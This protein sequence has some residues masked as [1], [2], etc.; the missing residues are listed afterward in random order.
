MDT[1]IKL[2]GH[3][4]E[5]S[6]NSFFAAMK[7]GKHEFEILIKNERLTKRE[8]KKIQVGALVLMLFK[9]NKSVIRIRNLGIWT[10]QEIDESLKTADK[11]MKELNWK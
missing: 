9:E 4:F 1:I 5:V 3:I 10:Q 6:K 8:Q 2:E 7:D 11:L